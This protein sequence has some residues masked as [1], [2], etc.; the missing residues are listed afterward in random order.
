[1][2]DGKYHGHLT[3]YDGEHV[4]LSQDDAQAL[5]RAVEKERADRAETMPATE[6]ALRRLCSAKE[7]LRELGWRDAIYCPK[8]GSTFA[9]IQYGSTGIF[10][11]NYHG[12]WPSGKLYCC[13]Y[14]NHPEGSMFKP[15]DALTEDEKQQLETC[16]ENDRKMAEREMAA[17]SSRPTQPHKQ[18]AE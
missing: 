1:M 7:R 13:D 6:D 16:M 18:G 5:W 8:D 4:P 10:Y 12:E 17:L 3:T 11:A 15:V 14:F 9:V 2:T